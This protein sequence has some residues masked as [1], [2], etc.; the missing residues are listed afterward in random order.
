MKRIIGYAEHYW[1]WIM[2]IMLSGLGCSIANVCIVDLL[3]KVID[4]SISKGRDFSLWI[5][6]VQAVA[7]ILV[8]M[9]SNYLVVRTTGIFGAA[10][11]RDLRHDMVNH[12]I[13]IAPND[14]EKQNFGEIMER[15]S[16]DVAVVAGYMET[17]FKD[18]LYVPIAVIVFTVYLV[19]LNPLLAVLSLGPLFIMVPISIKLLKPVKVAQT[20]YAKKLGLTNNHIQEVFDGVDVIKSYNLQKK[21]QKKYYK[22]LKE[23]L[24]ISNKNDLWQYN[25]E[26]L[27]A[28]IR[29]APTA[30]SLCAGGYLVLKGE[31]TIGILVAF[32]SGINKINEPLVYAYQL[33]VRTQMAMISVNR[34]LE[35]LDIPIESSR[36]NI[37]EFTKSSGKVF[38]FRDV[39]FSYT[40]SENDK[41]VLEQFNL[42]VQEGQKIA[43]VGK[44]GCG[45]ST[46]MKLMCRQN[47]VDAGYI[48]F[49]GNRFSDITPYNVREQ[50][51]L[52]AQESTIFPMS[53]LDN[54]RIGRPEA[55]REEII[56]AAQKAGC[57]DFIME[58]PEGYDT[59]LEERGNNLSG[60]QKQR[61]AIAR[62]ILK[63]A[64]VILLDEPTSALDEET[65][66]YVNQ[67]LL[68]ISENKTLIT[69]A[70]R[71]NTIV[72]YDEI[73][74]LEKG[75]IVEFG[76]HE[77][78]MK[79]KGIYC[80]MYDEYIQSGGVG[81]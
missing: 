59:L 2:L 52:I 14:M 3:K 9:L 63:D 20:E 42:S 80:R 61:I 49:F 55:D 47:E 13:K 51:S 37:Q 28:L 29:E 19:V 65:E 7:A 33:V 78:L 36:K 27:S 17:Y 44:S 79:K 62:A 5:L 39:F 32:I 26:P 74:V 58:L 15:V 6:I 72:D 40:N 60:G 31:L 75:K 16:A 24:D 66:K 53:V 30:I 23:T 41:P 45:K 11:L 69:V 68:S 12:L 18:C 64:P 57:H 35:I 8:G 46:I 10:V 70:H 4:L 67:T 1:M 76:T 77:T 48:Y 25:I 21:L 38:E 56:D 34:V 81:R 50:L 22:A 54:I 43:L 71:L 73:V